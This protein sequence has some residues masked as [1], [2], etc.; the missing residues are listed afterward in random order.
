MKPKH[1]TKRSQLGA[2]ADAI[3]VI[4]VA[5]GNPGLSP[6]GWG[7]MI[8][9]MA[10]AMV[11]VA[12]WFGTFILSAIIVGVFGLGQGPYTS[13]GG[14]VALAGFFGGLAAAAIVMIRIVRRHRR[15]VALAG[16]ADDPDDSG[17]RAPS[18]IVAAMAASRRDIAASRLGAL[19]ANLASRT[20]PAEPTAPTAPIEPDADTPTS[21]Q[22]GP[23]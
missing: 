16:F 10:I 9:M 19:D 2:A 6:R 18:P 20:G 3:D 7:S 21:A 5:S 15:L 11:G 4:A 22:S 14:A 13:L 1:P 12:I 8:V 23:D 17:S